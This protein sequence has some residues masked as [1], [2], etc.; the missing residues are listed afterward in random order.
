MPRIVSS[1]STK[2][3]S[4]WNSWQL[5]GKFLKQILCLKSF[6][7]A[8]ELKKL[9]TCVPFKIVT[10]YISDNQRFLVV[11]GMFGKFGN[12]DL[13]FVQVG[14]PTNKIDILVQF[15]ALIMKFAPTFL[16]NNQIWKLLKRLFENE[17]CFMEQTI[18]STALFNVKVFIQLFLSNATVISHRSFFFA[19]LPRLEKVQ[20]ISGK[21]IL[22]IF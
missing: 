19:V 8:R 17:M 5:H 9:R 18:R 11:L 13:Q 2:N 21:C 12:T 4:K 20:K 1:S 22:L 7:S 14:F 3:D 10:Y 16:S 6:Q 15:K